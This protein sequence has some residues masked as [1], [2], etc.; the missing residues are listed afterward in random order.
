MKISAIKIIKTMG[1]VT[2]LYIVS[3]KNKVRL[4]TKF[5]GENFE[6]LNT[7]SYLNDVRIFM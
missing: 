4:I 1:Y 6:D 2:E 7:K 3:M 5:V